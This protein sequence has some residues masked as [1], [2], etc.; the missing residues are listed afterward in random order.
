MPDGICFGEQNISLGC[1]SVG[2]W[3]FLEY[4]CVTFGQNFSREK[5][6]N[7]EPR[8]LHAAPTREA[9]FTW[10]QGPPHA[11]RKFTQDNVGC[12]IKSTASVL[13]RIFWR[14]KTFQHVRSVFSCHKGVTHEPPSI[15][16]MKVKSSSSLINVVASQKPLQNHLASRKR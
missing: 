1:Q 8:R 12:S 3:Y 4:I 15:C 11:Q 2:P 9:R 6:V 13:E 14:E 16:G 7:R 5:K 10:I